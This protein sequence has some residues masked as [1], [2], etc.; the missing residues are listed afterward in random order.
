MKSKK[1]PD[2]VWF[3]AAGILLVLGVRLLDHKTKSYSLSTLCFG[4]GLMADAVMV[5]AW[6]HSVRRRLLPSRARACMAAAALLFLFFLAAGA[7]NHR[8]VDQ[9]D[10]GF[11]RACWYLYYLPLLFTPSLFLITCLD[12]VPPRRERFPWGTACLCVSAALAALV[13]TNDLH[14]LVFIPENP[15]AFAT[16]GDYRY[17]VPYYAGFAF[18]VGEILFGAV[19]LAVSF[20]K[21]RQLF[22]VLLPVLLMPGYIPLDLLQ[23]RLFSLR[24]LLMPQFCIFCMMCFFEC[25]IRFRLIPYNENYSAFF[26]HMRFPAVITDGG[27]SPVY[28]TAAPVEAAREQLRQAL[29]GSVYLTEDLRLSGRALKAGDVFYTEDE[30]QLHRMNERLRDANE[31]LRSEQTLIRAENELKEQRAR[32]ESRSRI[33][34]QIA[35]KMV[36][37]R[38]EAATLL[39][40]AR[41]GAPEFDRVIARVSLLNAYIKRGANLLLVNEGE[42]TIPL[43]EL[44]LALEESAR[45]LIYLGVTMRVAR[46][47]SVSISRGLAFS[48]Y[49]SFETLLEA[50]LSGMTRLHAAVSGAG[51]R[52]VTDGAPPETMPETPLPVSVQHDD[53]CFYYIIPGGK[54]EGG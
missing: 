17:G 51:L 24:L 38:R 48:L 33:Y 29:A 44:A 34:A 45:Y 7:V 21:R 30:T 15:A 27:L 20:Q 14:L 16:Y 46:L 35:E 31:L 22:A 52:L 36:G 1:R 25:C 43:D 8:I 6:L 37:R 23:W 18:V 13:L 3:Y 11:K 32:A 53:G 19:R 42:D 10:L 26:R 50:S 2:P 28:R 4:V 49:E 41:P 54:G 47:D 40:D 12:I 39:E 5:F 9:A